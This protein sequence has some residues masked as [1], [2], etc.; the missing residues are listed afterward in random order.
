MI[1][2]KTK[3][4]KNPED[5]E[6]GENDTRLNDTSPNCFIAYNQRR[7]DDTDPLSTY[8]GFSAPL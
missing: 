3:E 4:L 8:F 2:N 7:N 6:L 5:G 1:G